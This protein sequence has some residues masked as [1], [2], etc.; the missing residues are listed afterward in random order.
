MMD[1]MEVSV[2][3]NFLNPYQFKHIQSVLMEDQFPWFFNGDGLSRTGDGRYQFVHGFHM[4]GKVHS[5]Y[6]PMWEP[7]LKKLGVNRVRRIKAN[8][9]HRTVF[10]RNGG[11]HCDLEDEPLV[12]KTSILYINTNN[13]YTR[14]KK[15]GKIKCVENRMVIFPSDLEHSGFSCTD[16]QR[17][18]IVNFNY[19]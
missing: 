19:E 14:F 12:A 10:H 15:G 3:D 2:T 1:K 7:T 18:V 17:K 5:E 4:H 16:E 13:G 6:Y 9:N 8:L 11:W